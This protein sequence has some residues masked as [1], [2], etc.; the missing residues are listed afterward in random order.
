LRRD[1]LALV[2]TVVDIINGAAYLFDKVPG[3]D[4]QHWKA[5]LEMEQLRNALEI[6]KDVFGSGEI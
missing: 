3:G 2:V 6:Q 5:D 4:N 1:Y